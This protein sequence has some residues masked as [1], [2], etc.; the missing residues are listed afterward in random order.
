MAMTVI[1]CHIA[2]RHSANQTSKPYLDD[3]NKKIIFPTEFYLK[4]N[5]LYEYVMK[6]PCTKLEGAQCGDYQ[7]AASA[8]GSRAVS[9][10]ERAFIGKFTESDGVD[11]LGLMSDMS[12]LPIDIAKGYT[13]DA[14]V[15]CESDAVLKGHK[16]LDADTH[17]GLLLAGYVQAIAEVEASV[18]AMR[19]G[20]DDR[21]NHHVA[22]AGDIVSIIWNSLNSYTSAIH[23]NA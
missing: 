12:R 13:F 7:A 20:M 1:I 22:L 2:C 23:E 6:G 18:V 17:G 15:V 14:A 5:W 21:I 8:L 3:P 11:F 9:H 4:L 19:Q 16:A 10:L